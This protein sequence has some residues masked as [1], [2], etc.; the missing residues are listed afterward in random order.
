MA[1]RLARQLSNTPARLM[2][3]PAKWAQASCLS[4]QLVGLWVLCYSVYFL[5]LLFFGNGDTPRGTFGFEYLGFSFRIDC[6]TGVYL[7]YGNRMGGFREIQGAWGHK[8]GK[9]Y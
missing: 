4:S 3:H 1:L 8:K 2:E 6:R 9:P 7:F 5:C